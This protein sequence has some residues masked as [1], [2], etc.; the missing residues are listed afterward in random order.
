MAVYLGGL[1]GDH[2]QTAASCG[3]TVGGSVDKL[4]A[5]AVES[6]HKLDFML[7]VG[8]IWSVTTAVPGAECGNA[9]AVC[10]IV[11]EKRHI[12]AS[13]GRYSGVNNLCAECVS[14]SLSKGHGQ[15]QF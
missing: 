7:Q 13:Y 10:G 15:G 5:A 9:R 11:G 3:R 2:S 4:V 8:E 12:G 14:I 6:R 1:L